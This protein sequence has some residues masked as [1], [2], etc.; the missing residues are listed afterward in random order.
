MY[1]HVPLHITTSCTCWHCSVYYT[2]TCTCVEG[3]RGCLEVTVPCVQLGGASWCCYSCRHSAYQLNHQAQYVHSMSH[4]LQLHCT[5]E[6][7][8]QVFREVWERG[9]LHT[10][11]LFPIL[12]HFPYAD[13]LALLFTC[14]FSPT[15]PLTHNAI[16][17]SVR[18]CDK[19]LSGDHSVWQHDDMAYGLG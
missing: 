13:A 14:S 11:V 8:F 9:Y 17:S 10:H 4:Q 7:C 15:A 5:H 2:C 19:I 1:I 18:L 3:L 16:N 6:P 12:T